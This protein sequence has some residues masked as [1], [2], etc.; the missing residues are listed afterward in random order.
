MEGG[1]RR[2]SKGRRGK[3]ESVEVR[4]DVMGEERRGGKEKVS[5]KRRTVLRWKRMRVTEKGFM[6][7]I[8][9]F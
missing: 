9:S 6:F 3:S 8:G 4:S 5:V 2:R 7:V 1:L